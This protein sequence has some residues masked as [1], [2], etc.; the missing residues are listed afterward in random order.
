MKPLSSIDDSFNPSTVN[1]LTHHIDSDQVDTQW[2][3]PDSSPS[4]ECK[5]HSN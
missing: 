5:I 4:N 1:E 2:I 3:Q